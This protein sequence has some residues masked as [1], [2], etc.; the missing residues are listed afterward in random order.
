MQ[1]KVEQLAADW[2]A[3]DG[4]LRDSLQPPVSAWTQHQH[5]IQHQQLGKD[6]SR[7]TLVRLL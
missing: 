5:A 4:R 7:K 2:K 6:Q 3:L 1:S